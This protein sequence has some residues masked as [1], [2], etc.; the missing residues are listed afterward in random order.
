MRG[1]VPA[2]ARQK[3]PASA[4]GPRRRRLEQSQ[5]SLHGGVDQ[6]GLCIV[7]SNSRLAIG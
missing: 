5:C 3:S 6:L 7:V 1:P 2:D 4:S